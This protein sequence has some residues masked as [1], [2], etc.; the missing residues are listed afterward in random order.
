MANGNIEFE[1]DDILL[2]SSRPAISSPQESGLQKALPYIGMALSASRAMRSGDAA[3]AGL[4]ILSG[5]S[6]IK[7]TQVAAAKERDRATKAGIEIKE[8]KKGQELL[9]KKEDFTLTTRF[10]MLTESQRVIFLDEYKKYADENNMITNRARI[11]LEKELKRNNTFMTSLIKAGNQDRKNEAQIARDKSLKI[12]QTKGFDSPEY[13]ATK[14]ESDTLTRHY[15]DSVQAGEQLLTAT[16][17]YNKRMEDLAQK[18]TPES[19]EVYERTGKASDLVPRAK[20]GTEKVAVNFILPTGETVLSYDGG[21]TYLGKDR[22]PIAMHPDA[23]KVPA[24]AT[25][26]ELKA[27]QA[28]KQAL[29]DEEAITEPTK[30]KTAEE[31]A[32]GGTGPYAMLAA[33]IDRF[34]GG[35]GVDKVFG[36]EGIFPETQE[37]RQILRTIKQ[38]G[39]AALINSPRFPMQEQKVVDKL[40]PD[41]DTFFVNPRTEAQ[42]FKVLRNVMKT[43]KAW[44]NKAIQSAIT[45]KEISDL[46]KNNL[47]ID[48]VL[49]LIGEG[50]QTKGAATTVK[51][52]DGSTQTF[53]E[54]G[55]RI[56]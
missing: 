1:E 48:R 44:N 20:A 41:P 6:D 32:K 50:E 17:K 46:R 26:S 43:E 13:Q 49:N 37:N 24:G 21:R 54:S 30:G 35:L 5:L 52:P 25:L 12:G 2:D 7:N 15:N 38:L 45:P 36:A 28:K 31:A 42:K 3:G 40:F 10:G 11:Q 53:D 34:L 47:E 33:G 8:L 55:K 9:D 56:E 14:K 19:M 23:V 51:M 29:E 22:E 27:Q 16:I 39:K 18:V 4:S